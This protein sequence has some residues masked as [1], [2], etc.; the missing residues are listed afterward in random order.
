MW[1]S[2]S[3]SRYIPKRNENKHPHKNMYT[4][5]YSS[6]I[7]ESQKVEIIQMSTNWWMIKCRI[8][9]QWLLF[10]NKKQWSTDSMVQHERS[11]SKKVILCDSICV[12][13]RQI[14]KDK[15]N[16]WLIIARWGRRRVGDKW[17]EWLLMG[18]WKCSKIDW[19]LHSSLEYTRNHWLWQLTLMTVFH[20]LETILF[21]FMS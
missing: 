7:H 10:V 6:I 14:W 4:N 2:N 5:V 20:I 9:V 13:Y 8:N 19:W 17:K 11:Q 16:Y 15:V 12:M 3:T 1:S 21:V 18:W